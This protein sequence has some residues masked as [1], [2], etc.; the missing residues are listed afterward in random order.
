MPKYI[1]KEGLE[2][3]KQELARLKQRRQEIAQ[4]LEEAKALGDLAENTEYM[5]A[6]E[7][8][9]FNEGRIIE[10]EQLLKE[11]V[12]IKKKQKHNVIEVG[13]TIEVKSDFGRQIFTIV[14]SQ[15]PDPIHGK[16]SNESPLGRAFLGHRVGDIM[17]VTTPKRKIK[18]KILRI[19]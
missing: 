6:K 15:E 8:Q 14:G 7:G 5:E 13:S 2:N 1:T 11:A 17:E 10:I 18:Y 12:L 9:A 4:R 16:I 19:K 3:F